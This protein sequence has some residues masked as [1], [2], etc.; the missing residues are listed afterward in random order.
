MLFLLCSILSLHKDCWLSEGAQVQEAETLSSLVFWPIKAADGLI[1]GYQCSIAV[2]LSN[3]QDQ[4]LLTQHGRL[5][6]DMVRISSYAFL[7]K[8]VAD[9]QI[10][11]Q[12]CLIAHRYNKMQRVKSLTL[13]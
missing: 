7:P 10:I 4:K 3:M 13:C 6:S 5:F 9:I 8:M 1:M 11:D 12:S 2:R